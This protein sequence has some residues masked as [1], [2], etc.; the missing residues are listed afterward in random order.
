MWYRPAEHYC[1]ADKR[2]IFRGSSLWNDVMIT[3]WCALSMFGDC[4]QGSSLTVRS[5]L[6]TASKLNSLNVGEY[7]AA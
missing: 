5:A 7:A 3:H 2:F 4:M 1:F 6:E